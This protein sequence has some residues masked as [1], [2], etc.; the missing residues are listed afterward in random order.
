MTSYQVYK[1]KEIYQLHRYTS[2]ERPLILL[3]EKERWGYAI[4]YYLL[5][6]IT[7]AML[8]LTREVDSSDWGRMIINSVNVIV[9]FS[10]IEY[11]N[12]SISTPTGQ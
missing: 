12:Q 9:I 11:V 2:T 4:Q 6:I 8:S 7:V 1:R 3:E 5:E 10:N